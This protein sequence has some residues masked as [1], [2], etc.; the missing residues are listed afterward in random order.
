MTS[1]LEN[2]RDLIAYV[3]DLEEQSEQCGIYTA[4]HYY[5]PVPNKEDVIN[6]MTSKKGKSSSLT[7]IDLNE[8]HQLEVLNEYKKVYSELPF[9]EI[10]QDDCRYFYENDWFSYADAIFLYSFLRTI[11]PKRIIEVG[12]GFSSAVILDTVEKFYDFSPDITFIE[13]YPDRLNMLLTDNDRKNI[14][15]LEKKIQ[16]VDEN[17]LTSLESG[18][19]LFIDSSHVL[20]YGSDL[21][22]LMFEIIP[23][24]KSGVYIHFHDVFFPFEYPESWLTEGRYWNENY[25]LRAFLA[26]NT[27]WKIHFFNTFVAN[28]FAD[29]LKTNMPLCLKNPGGSL[30]LKKVKD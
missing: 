25:L 16:D 19:L 5:S 27:V 22:I 17:I 12:S 4:G 18:D 20:K 28:E 26:Y 8:A 30:Y 14:Q 29:Y 13:P 1:K 21:Y 6:F 9:P 11:Q 7:E 24:L 2:F 10:K 3:K 15:I 23:K